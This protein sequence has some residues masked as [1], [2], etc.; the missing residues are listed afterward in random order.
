MS[1]LITLALAIAATAAVA[2][3]VIAAAASLIGCR[4]G[5]AAY[6]RPGPIARLCRRLHIAALRLHHQQLVQAWTQALADPAPRYGNTAE[7][8]MQRALQVRLR[9]HELGEQP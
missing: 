5:E 7:D 2:L 9:L 6:R 4:P 1:H 8:I 3:A